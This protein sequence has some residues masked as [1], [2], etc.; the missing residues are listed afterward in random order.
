ME[1]EDN[2]GPVRIVRVFPAPASRVFAA[3]TKP[4][5]LRKWAWGSLGS[6]VEV[7]LELRVGG[8]Y[9][10]STQRADGATW[11]FTGTYL[12]IVPNAKLA[13]TLQWDAPLGYQSPTES[14]VVDFTDEGGTC[15]VSFDH[16]GVPDAR[17]RDAHETGWQNTFDMLE[18]LLG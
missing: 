9:R 8:R 13:Y 17:S 11:S 2:R 1:H 10:I 5:D 12:E 18:G 4:E 16:Q 14:V 7:E 3:W 15:R 6:D